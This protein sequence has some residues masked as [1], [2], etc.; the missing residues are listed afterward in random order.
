MRLAG[1]FA[2]FV[3]EEVRPARMGEAIERRCG[4]CARPQRRWYYR[5]FGPEVS[6]L[7]RDLHS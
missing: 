4:I 1:S 5:R 7:N 6:P 2:I 3:M